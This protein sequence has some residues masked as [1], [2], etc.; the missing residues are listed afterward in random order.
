MFSCMRQRE[1][2]EA[3][4]SVVAWRRELMGKFDIPKNRV[5]VRVRVS[6]HR[7]IE[8]ESAK[9]THHWNAINIRLSNRVAL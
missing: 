3:L 1:Y 9:S 7:N 8:P 2:S 5:R 6:E 4:S